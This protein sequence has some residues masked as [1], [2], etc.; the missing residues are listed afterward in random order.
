[1]IDGWEVVWQGPGGLADGEPPPPSPRLPRAPPPPLPG[2]LAPSRPRMALRSSGL[3]S[4]LSITL[5]PRV[6]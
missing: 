4:S 6:E 5:T 1:M 3:L 2:L